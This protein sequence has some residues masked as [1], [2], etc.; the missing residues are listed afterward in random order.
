MGPA[1]AERV[2]SAAIAVTRT[3]ARPLRVLHVVAPGEAG[4]A[5]IVLLRTL[6]GLDA[7][8]VTST[9]VLLQSGSLA[10]RI[11]DATGHPPHLVP[12]GR[13]RNPIAAVTA[14][15]RI[16]AL[17]RREGASLVH[18]HGTP[19]QVYG[20]AAARWAGVPHVY[21]LHDFPERAWNGQGLVGRV[22]RAWRPAR[23]IANSRSVAAALGGHVRTIPNGIAVDEAQR[24]RARAEGAHIR[25]KHGFHE[26]CPL[27]VW[28]GRLQ[29][30][31][32]PDIFLRA[33][34]IV[35]RQE[36]R[37]R[38]LVVGGELFGL[39][40]GLASEL[41]RLVDALM[42]E[43]IVTFTG[44]QPDPW[45]YFAAADVVVHSSVRPEPFGLVIIE[46][47]AMGRAVVAADAAGPSEIIRDGVTGLLTPAAD[48][49]ALASRILHLLQDPARR[50]AIGAAA[51]ARVE[52]E[53]S[54]TQMMAGLYAVYDEV[55]GT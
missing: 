4:G 14:V 46:A 19:A 50:T 15:R 42:I 32:G 33:A 9:V 18:C 1:A 37:A 11:E 27:V 55:A 30:W 45:P 48:H 41:R 35:A 28:C 22:A 7:R 13:F 53:Y 51:R 24:A 3:A 39:E 6:G 43:S 38:F 36:P 2:R 21:H 20:G 16:R 29:R 34:A 31:K 25:A 44:H 5:E 52:A 23:T 12:A 47:M 17:I 26:D 8:R 10:G 40:R 54:L 49:Q